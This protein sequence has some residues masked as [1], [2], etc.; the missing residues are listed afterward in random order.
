MN[1]LLVEDD[2]SFGYILSEY[3]GMKGYQVELATNG[4]AG[5]ELALSGNFTLCIL[6]V[7]LPDGNGFSI[8]EALQ[9]ERPELPFIFLTART[10]KI[11]KLKGYRLG[12]DEYITKPVDEELL[13]AKIEAILR[14]IQP[15]TPEVTDIGIG[16]F[17]LDASL[18]TLTLGDSVRSLTPKESQL[19]LRLAQG[20]GSLVLRKEL[21]RE[22]WA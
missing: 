8:G 13:L 12:C 11:D 10:L 3:L 6:D 4:A 9:R 20:Q 18:Q 21:L 17:R 2:P 22:I 14:R 15:G 19:I 7:T 5:K 16:Q 1:I